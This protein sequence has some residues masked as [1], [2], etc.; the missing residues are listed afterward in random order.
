MALQDKLDAI[1]ASFAGRAPPHIIASMKRATADLV[2]T[3]QASRALQVGDRAPDFTL[4]GPDGNDVSSR[5]LLARGPLVITFYR[6]VWCPYCNAELQALQDALPEITALRGSLVA[7]SPESAANSRKAIRQ[8]ELSFPILTDKGNEVAAAV[9]LR[10]RLPD[11][12]I[13]IY[14]GFGNDLAVVNGEPS[15]TLPMPGRFV[16]A[17][18]GVIAYAEVNPDYTRRPDPADMMDALRKA[19]EHVAGQQAA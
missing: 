15:W 2:A 4:P 13:A 12:L 7:I 6:G 16:V 19:A 11:E 1:G 14:K 5:D 17:P 18:D 3:G 10:F 9:G 8:N